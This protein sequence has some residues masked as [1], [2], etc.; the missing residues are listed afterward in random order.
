VLVVER[1]LEPFQ[2]RPHWG[3]LF[4]MQPAAVRELYARLPDFQRLRGQLDPANKF[5]NDFVDRH[6]GGPGN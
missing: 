5:G 4:T 1:A 3:K 6:L 2:P